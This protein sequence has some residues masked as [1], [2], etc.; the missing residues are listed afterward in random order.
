VT[1]RREY[2]LTDEELK[3]YR[4][5]GFFTR[6]AVFGGDDL[7]RLRDAAERIVERVA[8][9]AEASAETY[10]IDGNRYAEIPHS[11]VQFEHREG[12]RTIRVIEPFHHLDPVFEAL[13]GDAR[14]VDPICGLLGE[15]SAALW[16][17]KINLKRPREG[18]A[19][20]WHQDSPYWRH[21]CRHCDRLPNVMI[22]LDDADER[23]GCFRVIRGS[24]RQGFLPGIQDETRL[25]PLFTDPRCFDESQQV[26]IEV[27]AGSLVFF[28]S[29]TVH[30]SR[31]NL[32]DANRRAMVLTYQPPGHAMFKMEGVR[33]VG[34]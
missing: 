17:D 33:E 14:I 19:F 10:T 32:S 11:T 20:R 30:G 29:H 5:D 24:H 21:V 26:A 8:H 23:N 12:S 13:V 6:L 25:G 18:S 27:P 2:E 31:P 34:R 1:R 22:A 15:E 3:R 9:V 28:D 16:T 7:E 4:E